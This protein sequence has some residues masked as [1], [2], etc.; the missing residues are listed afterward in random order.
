MNNKLFTIF[1]ALMILCIGLASCSRRE[2]HHDCA[3]LYL[4]ACHAFDAGC[5]LRYS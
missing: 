2:D 1:T 4:S 3:I 5:G